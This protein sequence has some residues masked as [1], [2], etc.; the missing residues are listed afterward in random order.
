VRDVVDSRPPEVKAPPIMFGL[1]ENS[2]QNNKEFPARNDNDFDK[3][4]SELRGTTAFYG[5]E[6][7][8]PDTLEP[9]LG[10][11]PVF[12]YVSDLFRKGIP[13]HFSRDFT[14]DEREREMV[15]QLD[16]GNHKLASEDPDKV[17]SLLAKDV[18]HDSACPSVWRPFPS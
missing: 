14:E 10:K 17:S 3:A 2:L 11:H 1:D 12:S 8:D 18:K 9:I 5:S 7:R 13:Y 15:A 16:R 6:F 4:M